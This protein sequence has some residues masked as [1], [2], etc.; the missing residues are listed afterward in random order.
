VKII[1][2][3][4]HK[5]HLARSLHLLNHRLL[6]HR[7]W[8]PSPP[9][10]A[11]FATNSPLTHRI[12]T[13]FSPILCIKPIE[14]PPPPKKKQQRDESILDILDFGCGPGRDLITFKSLGHRPTGL[15]GYC[16]PELGVAFNMMASVAGYQALLLISV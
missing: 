15:D 14:S 2:Y 1:K 5:A 10:P 3:G 7:R 13:A 12:S 4:N 9:N 11:H 8:R 16:C 6:N